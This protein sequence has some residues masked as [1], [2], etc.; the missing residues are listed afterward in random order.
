MSKTVLVDYW[1]KKVEV[2]VPENAHVVDFPAP[3]V[4][5]DPAEAVRQA[6]ANPLGMQR[7]SELVSKG[8]KVT[9]AFDDPCRPGLPRQIVIPEVLKEL[10]KAGVE[11]KDITLLAG[12]GNHRKFRKEELRKYLGDEVFNRFWKKGSA[13]QILNHECSDPD[14]LVYMGISEMGDYVEYNRLLVDSDLFIYCGTVAPSNWGGMTGCGVI[15]GLASARSM[16][17]T[18]SWDVVGHPDSCHGDHTTM[19][20]RSHKDAV[21]DQIEKFIGKKVF[22]V[23][24]VLGLGAKIAGVYAGHYKAIQKPAW[25]QVESYYKVDVPQCDV[26]VMGLPQYLLYGDSNN[27]VICMA[28]ATTVP[29]VWVN[30]PVLRKGGVVIC[31]A[32]CDGTVS[33]VDHP[34]YQEVMDLYDRYHSS[35]DMYDHEEEYISRPDLIFK[36]Q[37]CFGY[38]PVHPFWLYYESEYLKEWASKVIL[39]GALNPGAVRKVGLTPAKDFNA[40]WKMATQIVGDNP[41]VV[42]MPDFW[43]KARLQFNVTG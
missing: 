41:R 5:D 9:I 28:G 20:Y 17:S 36:Y 12:N 23:D 21:M 16:R 11:D 13:C 10:E 40:A 19:F 39:A 18:H 34:S 22:Y 24:C 26:F 1:D 32:R 38:H 4:L 27:P 31:M 7:I 6:L 3:P 29:R 30:K 33:P 8:S 2:E 25:Q 42:V 14:N 35:Q 43:S 15:I 37:N